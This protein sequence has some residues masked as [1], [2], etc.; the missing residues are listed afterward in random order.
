MSAEE[1]SNLYEHLKSIHASCNVVGP[2]QIKAKLTMVSFALTCS[3]P[4]TLQIAWILFRCSYK[5]ESSPA[6]LRRLEN[7]G[8]AF[9]YKRAAFILSR[10]AVTTNLKKVL[11]PWARMGLWVYTGPGSDHNDTAISSY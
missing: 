4:I 11:G 3:G 5:F 6:D 2:D 8:E 7:F 1:L 9:E 10:F